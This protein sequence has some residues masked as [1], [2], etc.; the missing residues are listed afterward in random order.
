VG[1]VVLGVAAVLV[2]ALGAVVQRRG[3]REL[4]DA[5]PPTAG[6]SGSAAG[7]A[8]ALRRMTPGDRTGI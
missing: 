1:F 4:G 8:A 6:E 5:P 3:R 7:G 2:L